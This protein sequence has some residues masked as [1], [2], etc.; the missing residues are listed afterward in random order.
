MMILGF[1]PAFFMILAQAVGT[2]WEVL[3]VSS[4]CLPFTSFW[5]SLWNLDSR[6]LPG[7]PRVKGHSVSSEWP[8]SL[9]H[10]GMEN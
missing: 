8:V 7:L 1:L 10:Q 3:G 9:V 6:S 5:W 2:T 4:A